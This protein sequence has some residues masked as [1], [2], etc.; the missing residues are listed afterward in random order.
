MF[1]RPFSKSNFSVLHLFRT[2][3]ACATLVSHLCCSCRTRVAFVLHSCCTCYTLLACFWYSCCKI[4]YSQ[5]S[6]QR[7]CFIV[8]ICIKWKFFQ[9]STKLQSKPHKKPSTQ[10]APIQRTMYI[11]E[12]FLRTRRKF[13]LYIANTKQQ[14]RFFSGEKVL[15]K[16]KIS[17]FLFN[18]SI[19]FIFYIVFNFFNLHFHPSHHPFCL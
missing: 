5:N 19:H 15:A 16:K 10:R 18:A 3:V 6:I 8:H 9:E 1:S 2:F 17:N 11:A 14:F 7:T 13:Y 4:D 12:I